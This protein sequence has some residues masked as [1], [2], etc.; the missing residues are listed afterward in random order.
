MWVERQIG[1]EKCHFWDLEPILFIYIYVHTIFFLFDTVLYISI[2]RDLFSVS[3]GTCLTLSLLISLFKLH[4]FCSTSFIVF[5]SHPWQIYKL[6]TLGGQGLGREWGYFF[7][8]LTNRYL[9]KHANI[10]SSSGLFWCGRRA[11]FCGWLLLIQ[12]NSFIPVLYYYKHITFLSWMKLL[13]AV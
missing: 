4:M 1:N 10:S 12:S 11:I 5:K 7:V 2:G 3:L 13:W 6:K 8:S 9:Q